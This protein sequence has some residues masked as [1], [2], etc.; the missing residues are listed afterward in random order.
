MSSACELTLELVGKS[1]KSLR[2]MLNNKGPRTDLDARPY[3]EIANWSR[4]HQSL[5]S[6]IDLLSSSLE[7]LHCSLIG[8][9][10]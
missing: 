10:L 3:E 9:M 2:K 5:P 8:H 4:H 6:E 7:I 1:N